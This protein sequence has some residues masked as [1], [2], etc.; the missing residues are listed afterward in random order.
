MRLSKKQ[1]QVD[2]LFKPNAQGISEW[3]KREAIDKTSLN[4]GG[5]GNCRHGIYFGDNRFIWKK[6][7]GKNGKITHLRTAGFS[8]NE[9]HGASRPVRGDIKKH[10]SNLE[11]LH[12]GSRTGIIA[13]HK[14]G[15]YNDPRVLNPITQIIDDFQPLCQGCNTIKREWERKTRVQKKRQPPPPCIRLL[16]GGA[17][18]TRGDS[19]FNEN[20]TEW[21]KGTYWGDIDAFCKSF[22]E[23]EEVVE[24]EEKVRDLQQQLLEC[25]ENLEQEK[26]KVYAIQEKWDRKWRLFRKFVREF[27]CEA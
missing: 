3:I 23:V 26:K 16:S 8:E 22:A 12:C 13:D 7:S 10:F 20:D 9:L 4:W 2:I 5:N 18:F 14:N 21:Y 1:I 15:L 11:C 24:V 17:L 27:V 6:K 25:E 19:T